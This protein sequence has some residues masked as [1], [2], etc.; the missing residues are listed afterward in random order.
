MD[1]VDATG[2]V[3]PTSSRGV[4]QYVRVACSEPVGPVSGQIGTWQTIRVL[5]ILRCAT[6]SRRRSWSHGGT[7]SDASQADT[8]S[9]PRDGFKTRLDDVVQVLSP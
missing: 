1:C 8:S 5:G 4:G 7:S 3:I 9:S 2:E 6:D